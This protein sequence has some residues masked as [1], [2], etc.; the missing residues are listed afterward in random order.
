MRITPCIILVIL[1]M[2]VTAVA[3]QDFYTL[4]T[5]PLSD[6]S[7]FSSPTPN[8]QTVGAVAATQDSKVPDA[9]TGSGILFNK[10]DEKQRFN[11]S[12]NLLSQLQ[13]GDIFLS[14]DFMM[15]KGSNS[16]VYLQ[17]RYEIQLFDSWGIAVPHVTDCG[18]IYE[19][20][21]DARTAG[22]K[23]YE[24]HPPRTNASLAPG[25]WQHLEI[26]FNAPRFDANGKKVKPARFAKVTLNGVVIHENVIVYGPT[27]AARFTD[28]AAQG[29][30]MLQGDHGP[31]AFKNIQYALLN[32]FNVSLNDL[33]YQYYEGTFRTPADLTPS[34]LTRQGKTDEMSVK[35][36]D[37]PNKMGLVFEGSLD[38]DE[39]S[40]YQF[41]AKKFGEL[42]IELDGTLLIKSTDLFAEDLATRTLDAG[43]HHLKITYIKN[44]GWAPTGLGVFVGKRNTRPTALHSNTSLP[45]L[46]PT[47]LILVSP[48]STPEIVRSF[49][50]VNGKKKTHVLS[51]GDQQGVHFSYDLNQ[52]GLITCW[53]GAFL[54]VTDMWY[55]RGEPQV[56]S[57]LGAP[58]KLENRCPLA[59]VIDTQSV[60]PDSLDDKA[61]R[62]EG[63][64]LD[65]RRY[66]TFHYRYDDVTFD[67]TLTPDV[68][69][70]GLTRTLTVGNF[71]QGKVLFLRLAAGREIKATG[72]G[73]YV[74]DGQRYYL[75]AS[76]GAKTEPVIRKSGTT[77]ELVLEWRATLPKTLQYTLLW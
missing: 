38:L 30:L 12:T 52:A 61:L 63:Y 6:L 7:A 34:A 43:K 27:R 33:T 69:T 64:T 2:S 45:A 66:P 74:I 76:F 25:L 16:G 21:D 19:R 58:M 32:D 29:P 14:L 42:T 68:G 3:Q 72:K 11:E 50:Y 4:T 60:L 57:P 77:S 5:L 9:T 56:A 37:N 23:G 28:E 22:V 48:G 39:K 65:V 40:D 49:M 36:A 51:L 41:I 47:P 53:R 75:H 26:E 15:P 1:A 55:E 31:V 10:P 54:N 20:W 8:W 35:L 73:W 17:G 24:G 18:S 62:Y 44:F 71:P 46:P 67:D 13:H 70:R 59:I